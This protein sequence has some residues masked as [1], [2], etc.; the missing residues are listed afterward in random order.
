MRPGEK[1]I[2]ASFS[3]KVLITAMNIT[4]MLPEWQVLL[5]DIFFCK[6]PVF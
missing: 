1:G 3:L 5:P 6:L 2:G 4:V